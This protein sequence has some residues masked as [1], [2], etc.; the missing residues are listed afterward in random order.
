MALD[1]VQLLA[2]NRAHAQ[3]VALLETLQEAMVEID[4]AARLALACLLAE[5]TC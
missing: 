5:G 4:R 2:L 1:E 3:S